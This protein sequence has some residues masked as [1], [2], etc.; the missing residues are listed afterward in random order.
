MATADSTTIQK[1]DS[2]VGGFSYDPSTLACYRLLDFMGYSGYRVGDDGTVWR[3]W[4]NCSGGRKLFDKWRP[5]KLSPGGKGYLRVNLT[6]PDGGTY[7]TFRVH[8]LVL[9]AFAGPCPDLMECRHLNGVR[10]NCRLV[11]VT[12]GTRLENTAD[13]KSHANHGPNIRLFTY[14]GRTL[15]LKAW[16]SEFGIP[17]LCLWKRI[18]TLGMTFEEAVSRPY[19]GTASNGGHWTKI[20]T[21]SASTIATNTPH[22]ATCSPAHTD[23]CSRTASTSSE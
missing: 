1:S 18:E 12:W 16:A 10:A 19:R 15:P 23:P 22:Q 2:P 14:D 9:I 4:V 11:N 3:R 21:R 20:K 5:M 7:Q 8:R 13:R 6:P 17:Y